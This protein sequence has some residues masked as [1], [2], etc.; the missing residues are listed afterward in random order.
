MK[1]K[2][3]KIP[4]YAIGTSGVNP[5]DL[6]TINNIVAE[7][8]AKAA[9]VQNNGVSAST[10]GTIASGKEWGDMNKTQRTGAIIDAAAAL[11]QGI[12]VAT[13]GQDFNVGQ[14]LNT[15][16][17]MAMAGGMIGGP[18]GAGIGAGV[19]AILGTAGRSAGYDANSTSTKFDEIYQKGSGWLSWFDADNKARRMA[20]MVQSSNIAKARTEDLKADYA[21]QG[22]NPAPNVLAAEGGIVPGEHYAS[23]GEVEV[24][25]DGTNAVR[26]G[27]DPKG[28]DT[29]H[30]YTNPDGSSA[31]GNIVFTE[32]GVKRPNG[33]KYSDAAEKIIKGTKEGS[34]LRQISL[35]KLANEMEEQK[36][37]KEIKKLK[38]GIPAHEGG[39]TGK[40][41]LAAEIAA[42]KR[43]ALDPTKMAI[44]ELPDGTRVLQD[45]Y[46]NQYDFEDFG[47]VDMGDQPTTYT[48][49][50]PSAGKWNGSMNFAKQIL[51]S[52]NVAKLRN[53]MTNVLPKGA[54]QTTVSTAGKGAKA[55]QAE[56]EL[57]K[58]TR[59]KTFDTWQRMGNKGGV[60]AK[61]V[62]SN[63]AAYRDASK[64]SRNLWEL[65]PA[66]QAASNAA[67]EQ[68]IYDGMVK[69]NLP[70]WLTLAGITGGAGTFLTYEALKDGMSLQGEPAAMLNPNQSTEQMVKTDN[71]ST[72][73]KQEPDQT[74]II[75]PT[76]TI[77]E[78][79]PVKKSS[80]KT[81][82][83]KIKNG[84][85][86]QV[87]IPIPTVTSKLNTD[88]FGTST[89]SF[90]VSKISNNNYRF[91][92]AR[93]DAPIK[94]GSQLP[95]TDTKSRTDWQDAL[96]R[97]AVL[98]Q[99]LWDMAKAEPVK[100]DIRNA[101]YIPVGADP[102]PLM[103]S[104]DETYG[105]GNYNFAQFGGSTGQ[106]MAYGV[107][108]ANN[109]AK[110]YADAYKWQQD[111]Q[112][113]QIAQNVGIYNDWDA[114]RSSI[115]NS[116]YDKTAA[117]RATAR[118]I[119]R[120]NR[121][122]ALQNY[123]QMLRD[124]KQFAMDNLKLQMM[125][126]M[127][128]YGYENYNDYLNWKKINR[129]G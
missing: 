98:T 99:P 39:K 104:A 40:E 52:K 70:Y 105:I 24:A 6:T 60:P 63:V 10:A 113:K 62:E 122:A 41:E 38:R 83:K 87:S 28:K 20:N 84:Q 29:Y 61:T 27:W 78:E 53:T 58:T 81:A 64:A 30:V 17:S 68:A 96:Y 101:K 47:I 31:V 97:T 111:V 9:S 106:R 107:A 7:M 16:T 33:E 76:K 44:I 126:P 18:L 42:R 15:T 95:S 66:Q 3:K 91:T 72:T 92:P 5:Y 103:K 65:T 129:Y 22:I 86:N 34:K 4:K 123:G 82:S 118:N 43:Q 73:S 93:N 25:A 55:V 48:G 128:Q 120:Q 54:T 37:G 19:G 2:V 49:V 85:Q 71:V 74:S 12:N 46:G 14:A 77:V 119:N 75:E 32:E 80:K 57:L 11:G 100:Y 56:K 108:L 67:A 112:N 88:K 69:H 51:N 45:L 26:Y 13:S 94:D 102:T 116:V 1:K 23:R 117:N 110:Q 50:A 79:T 21:N 8:N 90:D 35:R 127:L 115:M 36:M 59:Q 109:R 125:E 114:D 121:A 124:D 89:P